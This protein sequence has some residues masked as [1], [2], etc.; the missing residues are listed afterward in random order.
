M[1][2]PAGLHF[3]FAQARAEV[4]APSILECTSPDVLTGDLGYYVSPL[5][6][7][8]CTYPWVQPSP[9]RVLL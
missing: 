2:A 8:K 5:G 9:L 6:I 3:V 7:F 4:G 1:S